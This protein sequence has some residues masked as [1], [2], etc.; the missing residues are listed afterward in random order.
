MKIVLL[1]LLFANVAIAQTGFNGMFSN[2]T[3][4][5][6]ALIV[7]KANG[8]SITGTYDEGIYHFQIAAR[9]NGANIYGTLNDDNG[10]VQAKFSGELRGDNELNIVLNVDGKQQAAMFTRVAEI[11]EAPPPP[12]T[13]AVDLRPRDATL[14]GVWSYQ[15]VMNSGGVSMANA[16]YFLLEQN[17]MYKQFSKAVGGGA[18]WSYNSGD[19]E[20]SQQ[21]NWYAE[22]NI[23]YLKPAGEAAYT[24][25]ATY[26]FIDGKLITEDV[27]GR[28]IWN[29]E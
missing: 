22:K 24:A 25:A 14:V 7:L 20:L 29:K 6:E 18:D 10:L 4:N 15:N 1:F 3:E 23:L 28:Q 26:K 2:T 27:N 17:G 16:Y 19:A 11:V 9:I 12:A 8:N 5:V 13:G 21:G